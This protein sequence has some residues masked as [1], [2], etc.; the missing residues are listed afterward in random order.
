MCVHVRARVHVF[1]RT[2]V[3][4]QAHTCNSV[5][6]EVREQSSVVKLSPTVGS[7]AQAQ[8]IRLV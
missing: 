8:A 4:V 2:H 7:E 5:N 6:V 1:V 3:F